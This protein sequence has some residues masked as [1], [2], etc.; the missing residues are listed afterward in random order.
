MS[1][2]CDRN[3]ARLKARANAKYL[4]KLF[5]VKRDIVNFNKERIEAGDVV[6]VMKAYPAYLM[7]VRDAFEGKRSFDVLKGR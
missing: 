4:D 3:I 5:E 2:R 6:R 7:S 1:D